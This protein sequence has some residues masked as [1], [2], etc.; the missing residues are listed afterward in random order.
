MARTT[1]RSVYIFPTEAMFDQQSDARVQRFGENQLIEAIRRWLGPV[2][3]PTPIGM[4]D[5]C[6]VLQPPSSACKQLLT[7]DSLTYGQH[8]DDT[9]SPEKAGAKLIKRNLSDIA[10]MGGQ[11]GPA[12]LNLLCGPDLSVAWLERFVSGI[13][14]SCEKYGVSIVGGDV[15]QLEAGQFTASLTLIGYTEATP[16][17]RSTAAVG[18]SIYVTGRLGGSILKKH[19]DFEPRMKEGCWLVAQKVCRA[20]MDLTDGLGKDLAALLPE[21]SSAAIDLDKLPISEDARKCA[22]E[23]HSPEEHAFCDGEDYELLFTVAKEM[24]LEA[25]EAKWHARF[26]TLELTRI[27][28][29]VDA[30][31]AGRYIDASSGTSLPWQSGFE[32][33]KNV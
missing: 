7:T 33:F 24:D 9:A 26:P 8:F 21:Q 12:L 28:E 15:S 1:V 17:L 6:A 3:P 4:G 30:H 32:H 13:R 31:P 11:P 16:A 2:A 22:D 29:I 27:G 23:G 19:L 20:M 25:F 14:E 10:A 5:D 18:D